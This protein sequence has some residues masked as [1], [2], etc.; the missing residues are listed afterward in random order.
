MADN[1]ETETPVLEV[2]DSSSSMIGGVMGVVIGVVLTLFMFLYLTLIGLTKNV[3]GMNIK[4]FISLAIFF[5]LPALL[6]MVIGS[7]AAVVP[8]LF[9]VYNQFIAKTP[10]LS[11]S[12]YNQLSSFNF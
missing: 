8:V 11:C 10:Y 9:I 5:I 1:T 7:A 12:G 2:D 6:S 3:T 4:L